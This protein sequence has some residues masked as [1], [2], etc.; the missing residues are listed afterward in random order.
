MNLMGFDVD[1][2]GNHNFD[3]G[4][5][6]LRRRLIPL[7]D[8]PYVSSNIVNDNGATPRQWSPSTVFR[9]GEERVGVIGF[10]N[11]DIPELTTPGSL[12][13]FHVE[14]PLATVNAEAERLRTRGI[15]AIVAIGHLG[16]T[17]GTVDDPAGP[18]IELADGVQNVD[19]VIGDHTNFQVADVRPNGVLV[20]ENLSKG[21]RFTRVRLTLDAAT[22][23]VVYK[24]ADFHKPWN[25]G[26][27]PNPIIQERLDRLNAQLAPVLGVEVGESTVE[28]PRSDSCGRDDGRL[29]ES[30]L[31]NVVTDSMRTTY[32]TDFAITNSGGLR[33]SLTCPSPDIAGDFCGSFTPPPWPIT[34]GQV[35]AVLPFGNV[36]STATVTGVELKAFLENGVSSMPEANGRFPQVSGL[37]FTF[38]VAASVGSRVTSVVRANPDGTCSATAVDLGAAA[39]YT[40]A[41]NDFMASGGD[42]YPVVAGKATTRELMDVV[43]GDYVAAS[44]PISPAIQGRIVCTG[45]ACPAVTAP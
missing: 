2:L 11:P 16:A 30:L 15:E 36:V 17:G 7:A 9:F 40:L 33:A 6:Y 19:A 13:P 29:C 22:G 28:V 4:E 3:R 5:Q 34:R 37:C 26:V 1:G 32:G 14:D 42:G 20:T 39:T 35:L 44:T 41:I 27:R 8:F 12:G 25:I 24:T 21:V 43:L 45:A 23:G 18:L 31:G 10:S 38:D